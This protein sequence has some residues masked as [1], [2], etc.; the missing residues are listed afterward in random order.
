MWQA[1]LCSSSMQMLLSQTIKKRE[2]MQY[3]ICSKCKIE[4]PLTLEF[5]ARQHKN[6]ALMTTQCRQCTLEYMQKWN[7]DRKAERDIDWKR[8]KYMYEIK[9]PTKEEIQ[10]R[11]KEAYKE[12]YLQAFNKE[13]PDKELKKLMDDQV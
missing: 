13:L 12:I 4:K 7:A 2:K 9:T 8:E 1:K 5:F 3:R 11:M 10:E 6:K